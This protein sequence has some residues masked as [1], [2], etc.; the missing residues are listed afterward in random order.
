MLRMSITLDVSNTISW[1]RTAFR[2]DI[3]Y[4]LV[5]FDVS[6]L[7]CLIGAGLAC[8]P[9]GPCLRGLDFGIY[10]LPASRKPLLIPTHAILRHGFESGPEL[11]SIAHPPG[12]AG[13]FDLRHEI[14]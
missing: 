2:L 13:F 10:Q 3:S 9:C 12:A 7:V 6:T 11:L 8:A 4:M 1:L 5:T 14:P